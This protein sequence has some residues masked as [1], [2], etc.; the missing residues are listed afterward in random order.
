MSHTD[1]PKAKQRDLS[2]PDTFE[3]VLKAVVR[4]RPPAPPPEKK[5]PK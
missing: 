5:S 4:T 3:N 2:I 1:R